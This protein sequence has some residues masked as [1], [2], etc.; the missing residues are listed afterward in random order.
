MAKSG[1][2]A[3]KRITDWSVDSILAW[4]WVFLIAGIVSTGAFELAEGHSFREP[5]FLLELLT[6]GLLV[7]LIGWLFMT[8]LAH[9]LRRRARTDFYFNLHRTLTQQ[10]RQRQSWEELAH[11]VAQLPGL[12]QAET[13]AA[14]YIYDHN[15]ARLEFGADSRGPQ[16]A[17]PA[18]GVPFLCQACP[19]LSGS[20][21][22]PLEHCSLRENH[23]C[24]RLA[25]DNILVGVLMMEFRP[26]RAMAADQAD[27]L[28]GVSAEIALALALQIAFPRQLEAARSAGE[29]NERQRISYDLHDNL[30]QQVSFLHLS[31]DRLAD[32]ES[33]ADNP[34][35]RAELERTRAVAEEVYNRVRTTLTVLR[36]QMIDD[37]PRL[38]EEQA[39]KAGERA[40]FR[41]VVSA[42]GAPAAV[43]LPW[44]QD[45]FALVREGLNNI[46]KHSR[47]SETR[48]HLDWT[49][50]TLGIVMGDNG[51]GFDPAAPRPDGHYG[52][53][54]MLERIA[55]LRGELKIDS[56]PGQGARLEMRVPLPETLARSLRA[57]RG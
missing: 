46:E 12:L 48:I 10:L 2:V 9:A 55:R 6:S 11:Y 51:V 25:Y 4:R 44:S 35:L 32:D 23:H 56:S 52:L 21:P 40:G 14:L 29:T 5:G 36:S 43:P 24:L 17:A 28:A 37:L 54:M 42:G 27:F 1:A 45:V 47:A 50:E 13:Q 19:A 30:A 57:A 18:P 20:R 31:L 7:P 3:P 49:P 41:A 15:Q 8:G 53:T 38:I 33:L 34:H 22:T 39:R 16:A 26:G